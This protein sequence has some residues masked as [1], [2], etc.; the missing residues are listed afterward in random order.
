MKKII[1]LLMALVL[2]TVPLSGCGEKK[3]SEEKKEKVTIALWGNQ[4]LE[5]YVKYICDS[6]PEV[7]FEFVLA[8]NSTD[9]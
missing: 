8:T 5:N 6:F 2:T 7:D 9:Y 1:S 3:P 4:M